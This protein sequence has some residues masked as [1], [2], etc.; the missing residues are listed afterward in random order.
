[1]IL[2]MNQDTSG[3]FLGYQESLGMTFD[4]TRLHKTKI[5]D[6]ENKPGH[7]WKLPEVSGAPEMAFYITRLHKT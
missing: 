2:K 7:V 6:L 5:N 4:T 1:M 3:D